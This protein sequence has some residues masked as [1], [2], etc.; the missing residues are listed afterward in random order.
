MEYIHSAMLGILQGM[1]EFLPISSSGHLAVFPDLLGM[2]EGFLDSLSFSVLLHAGTLAAVVYYFRGKVA[3][4][5]VSF[6]KG[7]VRPE[8]RKK[9]DYR[10]GLFII[11]ATVPAVIAGLLLGDFIENKFRECNICIASMLVIFGLFLYGADRS[12]KKAREIKSMNVLDAVVIGLFQALALFPGVSR[13]GITMTAGLIAGYKREDAAEFS[14]LMSIPAIT[15]AVAFEAA[16]ILQNGA[17]AGAGIILT[18]FFAA[19]ISGFFAIKFLMLF[20]KG[21]S[22]L[23]F[24]VYRAVLGGI[25][26]I[27]SAA[28]TL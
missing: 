3:G 11:I 19:L 13:A 26:I 24:A 18:G 20:V 16:Y 14:F 25:I 12:G 7:F 5:L 1:T 27:F 28:G 22:F 9:E 21:H 10:T 4:M 8:E 17:G 6:F 2:K 23:L 15:G